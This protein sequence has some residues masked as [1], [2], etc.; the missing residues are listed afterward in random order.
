MFFGESQETTSGTISM[1]GSG[2]DG[3]LY[4]TR[5]STTF[6]RAL[7]PERFL[8]IKNLV[9]KEYQ[10]LVSQINIPAQRTQETSS[11]AQ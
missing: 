5:R 3:H 7:N 9:Q 2:S 6:L 1:D 10:S 11:S 8:S 4:S